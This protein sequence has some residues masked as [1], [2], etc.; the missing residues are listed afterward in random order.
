MLSISLSVVLHRYSVSGKT[1][2]PN[3]TG[4][5]SPLTSYQR[6]CPMALLLASDIKINGFLKLG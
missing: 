2:P 5:S 1:L 6:T 3:N 4:L